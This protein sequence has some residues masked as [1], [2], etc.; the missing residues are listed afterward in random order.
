MARKKN[1]KADLKA[2]Y[3][4]TMEIAIII[5]L[6][7]H[8]FIFHG[9]PEFRATPIELKP[10]SI[11]I[12]VEDIPQTQQKVLP[13]PPARPSVPIPTESEEVPEDLT[14]ES[15][16]LNWDL[17]QLPPPPPPKEDIDQG[18][19]FVPY[20]EPPRPI[21]GMA[22]IRKHLH[23]P[24]IARKLG[25][26]GIVVVGVLIDENGNPIKTQVLKDSGY[27]LGFEEAAQAAVMSV[28]WIPAK[29]R[30]R[31]VKVWVSIPIRFRLKEASN[32]S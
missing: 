24:E 14:I 20:D 30:D 28:K 23:Y 5:S 13:P 10:K 17:S 31:K 7:F 19:V 11:E 27:K 1:P 8:L 22:A 26:E 12:K 3:R 9:L 25:I 2:Q 21:G 16:E 6:V 4:K 18:Y 32:V 15:T 29:Q